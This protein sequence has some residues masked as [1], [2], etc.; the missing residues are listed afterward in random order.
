MT[1]QRKRKHAAEDEALASKQTPS[2][3]TQGSIKSFGTIG[4]Q[5]EDMN[6]LK[7]RKTVHHRQETPPAAPIVVVKAQ[8]K[9]KRSLESVTEESDD[10][11]SATAKPQTRI[12]AEFSKPKSIATP[13]NKR[14]KNALPLSPVETPTKSTAKLLDK[15]N[16]R[17]SSPSIPSSPSKTTVAYETPPHTPDAEKPT[18]GAALPEELEDLRRLH[19]AFLTALSLHYAHNGTSTPVDVGTLLPSIT[20]SWKK[21]TVTLDDLRRVLALGEQS[22]T[23]QDYGRAGIC[24]SRTQPRGRAT[25]RAASYIDEAELNA[26]FEGDLHQAWHQWQEATSKE[27]RHPSTFVQQL[28]LAPIAKSESVEKAAPLFA[29]GQQ[30]LADLKASQ[31][32]ARAEPANLSQAI[33]VQAIPVQAKS[34][35]AIQNRGTSL[36]DRV[37]AKQALT[38]SMPASPTREQLER[39]S[40]LQRIEEIARVLELL[41]AGRPRISFS[42]QATVQHL[43]QSLRNP[44]SREDIER[45]LG[46]MAKEVMPEFVTLI[47]SGSVKGVIVTR[48]GKLGIADMKRR[49]A[50][51]GA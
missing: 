36:L 24:L 35:A 13:R 18:F 12:F 33:P 23:L 7:K 6:G 49:L 5:H 47:N 19:A 45:C 3:K 10:E 50:D 43:Q 31:A 44:I 29:R 21:R 14:F 15:L 37:L 1:A 2:G 30:R 25:K 34:I 4:K 51:A 39:K 22:F 17:S 38:A 20:K 41:A 46:L 16:L 32:A 9:R 26:R 28:S 40:A 11:V 27:N 42:M 8:Q 48:A